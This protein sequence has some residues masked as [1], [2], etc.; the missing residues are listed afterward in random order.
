MQ[1]N[2]YIKGHLVPA[3]GRGVY[4]AKNKHGEWAVL[5]VYVID[6]QISTLNVPQLMEDATRNVY[7]PAGPC[8]SMSSPA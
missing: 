1:D 7:A 5:R 8:S 3:R 2:E 4:Q 6:P